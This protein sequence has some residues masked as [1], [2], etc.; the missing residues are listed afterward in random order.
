MTR[1]QFDFLMKDERLGMYRG[2][3]YFPAAHFGL[4]GMFGVKDHLWSDSFFK[5][6]RGES[7]LTN[8]VVDGVTATCSVGSSGTFGEELAN[9]QADHFF[10]A[11]DHLHQVRGVME[12]PREVDG[13]EI[14]RL[15]SHSTPRRRARHQ[16]LP[17]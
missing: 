8:C 7:L 9:T 1:A 12:S 13:V 17:I 3:V 16:T 15:P 6:S 2:L 4:H 14:L 5:A 11:Q 10:S